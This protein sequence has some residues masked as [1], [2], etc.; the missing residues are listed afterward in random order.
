MGV[1]KP[2]R[3]PREDYEKAY[4]LYHRFREKVP[5]RGRA[6]EFEMPTVLMVMGNV[7]E[8]KYDTTRRGKTEKYH[9]TF[10][11]GSRP[12]LCADGKTGQLFLV[13]G[14]YHVTPRGIVDLDARGREIDD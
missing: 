9:H 7:F 4:K 6:V 2:H 1:K 14:R 3:V 12:V 10:A 13:E 8:I 11:E 5:D